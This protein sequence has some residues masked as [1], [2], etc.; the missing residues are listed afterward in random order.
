MAL[1]CSIIQDNWNQVWHDSFG[2]VMLLASVWTSYDTDGIIKSTILSAWSRWL[3]QD[4]IWHSWHHQEHQCIY[5]LRLSK[6]D[7]TWLFL[8]IW[9]CW[10]WYQHHVTPMILPLSPLYTLHWD[11]WNNVQYNFFG[12]A[13]TFMPVSGSYDPKS[14]ING[15]IPLS[16][17]DAENG[18]N[19]PFLVMW[20]HWHQIQHVMPVVSSMAPLHLFK[21][22]IID[23]RCK[24]T[25]LVMWY[26]W[27]WHRHFVMLMAFSMPQLHFLAQDEPKEM[28]HYLFG[29]MMLLAPVSASHGA[30]STVNGTITFMTQDNENYIQHNF[31]TRTKF[32]VVI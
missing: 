23:M 29:N 13:M 20:C 15:T 1:H 24:M 16:G 22:Q 4:T 30:N 14:I 2:L 26:I 32:S 21:S 19:M 18:I 8:V 31:G 6:W 12:Q 7:A 10:H 9:H 17:H 27:S 11:D 5:D 3:R 28:Q 25:L